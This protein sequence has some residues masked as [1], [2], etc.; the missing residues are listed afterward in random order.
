M[1]DLFKFL[2]QEPEAVILLLY[3]VVPGY[4]TTKVYDLLA[5]GERRTL[6]EAIIEIIAW[7]FI[8]LMFWFWPFVLL[9]QYSD[10]LSMWLRYLIAFVLTVLA[11]FVTPILAAYLIYTVRHRGFV[12]GL[13]KGSSSHPSPTSWDW[14]FS[15]KA[16]NYYIKFH[17]KTGENLGG[18]YGENSF[19]T[20]FPNKQE[21]YIEEAWHLDEDGKFTEPIEGTKGAFVSREDCTLVQF[22]EVREASGNQ[23]GQKPIA[24]EP[25]L[26]RRVRGEGYQSGQHNSPTRTPPGREHH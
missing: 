1:T 9:Y 10:S 5:P 4:I 17:L 6:G 22:L 14:F 26:E 21:V 20:S 7:S 18:Y 23:D 12:R 8:L 25:N 19:A 3:L 13:A 11:V 2:M 16:N 15:E 24:A